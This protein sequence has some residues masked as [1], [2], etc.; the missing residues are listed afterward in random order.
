MRLSAYE[1]TDCN[2][3]THSCMLVTTDTPFNVH[4]HTIQYLFIELFQPLKS[5]T[6]KSP[7]TPPS[8]DESDSMMILHRY[9]HDDASSISLARL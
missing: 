6:K 5:F 3:N 8:C 7:T 1:N 2:K 4:R 9:L